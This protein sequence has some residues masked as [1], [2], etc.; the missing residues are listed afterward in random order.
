MIEILEVSSLHSPQT[1]DS[2]ARIACIHGARSISPLWGNSVD[3]DKTLPLIDKYAREYI[4][5][6]IGAFHKPNPDDPPAD[7]LDPN[8]KIVIFGAISAIL[9]IILTHYSIRK[10]LPD[11]NYYTAHLL[12]QMIYWTGTAFSLFA[13]LWLA[14]RA[15]RLQD[16]VSAVFRILP[17][18]YV[19]GGFAGFIANDFARIWST[20]DLTWQTAYRVTVA[21]Q[22]MAV[23]IYTPNSLSR[24][25]GI[26]RIGTWI[27]S[28]VVFSVVFCV[29]A[30]NWIE[31]T[32]P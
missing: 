24:I 3:I 21:T 8:N 5:S 26:E 9:G 23:L 31:N 20:S 28:A 12:K 1:D 27:G 18:A 15:I 7:F 14:R 2:L 10:S 19:L 16:C 32:A 30:L 22:L 6:I 29:L 13:V 25:P 4:I 11:A 17:A